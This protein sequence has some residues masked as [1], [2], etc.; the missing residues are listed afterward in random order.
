[1]DDKIKKI[2]ELNDNLRQNFSG[3]RVLI[4][5][6]VAELPI[7]KKL[8]IDE[9]LPGNINYYLSV[10]G[11]VMTRTDEFTYSGIL[12]LEDIDDG[13]KPALRINKNWDDIG[14]Y[15]ES[16]TNMGIVYNNNITIPVSVHVIQY[17]GE[18]IVPYV[19]P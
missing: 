13:V 1:M 12:D 4:T 9:D 2:R 6:G 8:D 3:G 10:D 15:N 7:D 14:S 18:T 19:G 11:N 5:R 16:D 17:L